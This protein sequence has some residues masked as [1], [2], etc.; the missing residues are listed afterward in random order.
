LILVRLE[1]E[2]GSTS[3]RVYSYGKEAFEKD[4]F[5]SPFLS[6]EGS[7]KRCFWRGNRSAEKGGKR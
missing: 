3:R 2:M 7:Q 4:R 5:A 1:E 6:G